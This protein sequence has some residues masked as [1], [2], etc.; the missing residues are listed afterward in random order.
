MQIKH[1]DNIPKFENNTIENGERNVDKF[2]KLF[3][4]ES[5]FWK[6]ASENLSDDYFEKLIEDEILDDPFVD[7][8][9]T[10]Q[11]PKQIQ[12]DFEQYE[13]LFKK[14]DMFWNLATKSLK[15]EEY[16]KLVGVYVESETIT[17][18]NLSSDVF[19]SDPNSND[20]IQSP[21]PSKMTKYQLPEDI[22]FFTCIECGN[23]FSDKENLTEHME[24][25]IK[26]EL[27][28]CNT[29]FSQFASEAELKTHNA[30]H[31]DVKPFPCDFCKKSFKIISQL[32]IHK[33]FSHTEDKPISCNF[34]SRNFKQFDA[35]QKHRLVHQES[36]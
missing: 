2:N 31:E 11:E 23:N 29:C 1:G 16:E 14:A 5:A 19:L 6:D 13:T 4:R 20:Q 3:E 34:C 9:S 24:S 21:K 12:L 32:R 17:W 35:L 36:M 27:Y 28:K 30:V 25:H 15:D 7:D 33:D 22:Q 10:E 8:N 26:Q 18:N